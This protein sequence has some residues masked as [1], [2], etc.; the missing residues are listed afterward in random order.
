MNH[1]IF[2]YGTLAHKQVAELTGKTLAFIPALLKGYKRNFRVLSK[3]SGFAAAGI[4]KTAGEQCMGMLVQVSEE[5]LKKFDE[6]ER[7][8]DRIELKKNQ[9]MPLITA[10]IPAG[11]YYLYVPKNPQT[12]TEACPLVQS[13]LDV[14]LMPYID[15]DPEKA[16]EIVKGMSDLDRPWINDRSVP[17]YAR[18]PSSIDTEAVDSLLKKV[19]PELFEERKSVDAFKVKPELMKSAMD[20]IRFFDLFDFPLTPEE[21]MNYLYKYGKPLHIKELQATL[22]HLVEIGRLS[23]IKG[24]FVLSGRESLA[25]I[26]KARKF[27][28]EKFWNRTKLYGTYMR[29]VPFTKMIAVCNNLAYNNPSESSDIDLFIVVK[30]GRMWLAR[31]LITLILHFY[32][33]RRHGNK[34]AGRFCLSFFVTSDKTHMCEFELPGEDPYLAYWAKNLRPIFGEKEYL[35]FQEKNRKWLAEYGLQF[36]DTYKKHMYH[37]EEGFVKKLSEWLLG[38]FLGDQFEKLLKVT[39]KKKTLRSMKN[40]GVNANVIVTDEILKFH[41]YDRRKEFLERWQKETN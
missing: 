11:K 30:P 10:S 35:E 26:R 28:A 8:Y 17:K 2:S 3:S 41:N 25:E 18:Y 21:V 7:L 37:Y 15:L 9:L 19:V 36:D 23:S 16:A 5:E 33:V 39:L 20:T 34:I 24:Y 40:L 27:I 32:G 1:Y 22:K 31:F 12:P 29:S 4:D 14:I 38:G 6:R 13:Y